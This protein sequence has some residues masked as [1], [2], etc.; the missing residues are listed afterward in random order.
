MRFWNDAIN[1]W[2]PLNGQNL[3]LQ[4]VEKLKGS[5]VTKLFAPFS[6]LTDNE[7]LNKTLIVLYFLLQKPGAMQ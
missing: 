1:E 7:I 4:K 6:R 3:F 2:I 5:N